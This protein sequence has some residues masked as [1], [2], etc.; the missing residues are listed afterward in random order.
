MKEFIKI[1]KEAEVIDRPPELVRQPDEVSAQ[2]PKYGVFIHDGDVIG[3]V[4]EEALMAVLKWSVEKARRV[5]MSVPTSLGG[6]ALVASYASRDMAETV[7]QAIHDH[8]A[9]NQ[10]WNDAKRFLH[11]VGDWD[12]DVTAEQI[13]D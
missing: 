5:T 7:A 4:V 13:E 8:A 6:R 2:P 3:Q 9:S 1:I 12:L 11:V 10:R